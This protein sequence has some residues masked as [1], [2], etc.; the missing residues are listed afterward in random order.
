MSMIDWAENEVKIACKKENPN[1]DGKSFDYGCACYQSALKA[2]KSLM[3]D[4]HSGFSWNVTK[5]ILIR[6]MNNMPLT[7][8]AEEDF[9]GVEPIFANVYQCP[10]M[11]SLFKE[12][13]AN[14]NIIYS[15]NDR[16]YGVDENGNTYS[17]GGLKDLC[18]KL[19]PITLPYYPKTQKY[20]FYTEEFLLDSEN[21]DFDHKAVL[22]V[23]TPE[24]DKIELDEYYKEV[25]G[26]MVKIT[27]EEYY[28]DKELVGNK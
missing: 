26:K 5:N 21:G 17:G 11:S 28:K 16:Y 2:Y 12:V 13:D 14:G 19:F 18:D 4:D 1:W 3:D 15:D 20:V 25:N 8:I 27:K 24:G 6:L 7:A 23:R 22:Y 10:R 9:E